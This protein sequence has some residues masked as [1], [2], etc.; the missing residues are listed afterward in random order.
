MVVGENRFFRECLATTLAGSEGFDPVSQSESLQEAF[1]RLKETRT[2]PDV[3]LVDDF[4]ESGDNGYGSLNAILDEFPDLK[5]VVL[6]SENEELDVRGAVEAGVSGYLLQDCC[7]DELTQAVELVLEGERICSS[8]IASD[9]FSRLAS[10]AQERRR[11]EHLEALVLTP[12]ELEILQL[13]ADGMT[14]QEIADHL[15]LSLYTVKNHVHNI[16]EKLKVSHRAEAVSY[17]YGKRW[18]K[19]RSPT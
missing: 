8:R 1:I 15:F 6:G 2:Q 9:M 14:N 13:I 5:V 10:L 18:L 3:L 16:F 17:A 11:Q 4:Q 19:P 7:L 12:R